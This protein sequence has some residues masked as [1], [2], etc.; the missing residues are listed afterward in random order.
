MGRK[1]LSFLLFILLII[2]LLLAVYYLSNDNVEIIEAEVL[3]SED[4]LIEEVSL[5]YLEGLNF[6]EDYID[7]LDQEISELDYKDESESGSG[8]ND[9]DFCF[10][11]AQC[12]VDYS[13]EPY[14]IGDRLY[15][16]VHDFSCNETC[17][18]D[19][20]R[21]MIEDC[22]ISCSDGQCVDSYLFDC[23]FNFECNFNDFV[24][25]T[26]CLSDNVYQVYANW[27]CLNPGTENST[28]NISFNE[29]LVDDCGTSL[30]CNNGMCVG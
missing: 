9:D 22:L 13:E 28:C 5:S 29:Q 30:T 8:S 14:C 10:S 27:T 6:E 18:E 24:G 16:R 25:D 4:I 3:I 21:V 20:N 1:L 19:V 23:E 26:F 15:E 11:E 2:I 17:S 12:G 7:P